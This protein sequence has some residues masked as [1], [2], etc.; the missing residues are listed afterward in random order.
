V[1][2]FL[3]GIQFCF[4]F[5]HLSYITSHITFTTR[6]VLWSHGNEASRLG[7]LS[8]STF[9]G[10]DDHHWRRSDPIGITRKYL[11]SLLGR[12]LTPGLRKKAR[13]H[14]K[15]IING[16]Y[17]HD[18]KARHEAAMNIQCIARGIIA[19]RPRSV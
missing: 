19:R 13:F 8:L 4:P 3:G 10:H 5:Y 12:P 7:T 17:K 1:G 18:Y 14:R 2:F 11:K 6:T 16:D 9:L 15:E